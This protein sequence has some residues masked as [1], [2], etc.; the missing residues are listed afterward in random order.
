[1]TGMELA[2]NYWET[3]GA[4][5]IREEFPELEPLIAAALTGRGSECYGFDDEVSRDHDF[6]PGFCLF[7]PGEDAVDRR[8]AFLLERAYA[9]L[10]A[11]FEG[12]RRQ[13]MRPVALW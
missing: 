10:P 4:P 2:R 13:R 8:T 7:L 5:M 6:E 3:C 1:M 9:K 12:F 11:E